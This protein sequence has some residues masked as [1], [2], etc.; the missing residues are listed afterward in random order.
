[1]Q[2]V[3]V[4]IFA[5]LGAALAFLS[6]MASAQT[7]PDTGRYAYH[8]GMWWDGGWWPIMMFG[9]LFMLLFLAVLI[10][11]VIFLVRRD[12][13]LGQ[14]AM[15][16]QS[17]PLDILKERFARGEIDKNEFEERRRVLGE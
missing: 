13:G 6:G 4:P 14:S 2:R 1:M 5:A 10:A 9:P 16:P 12:G 8:P 11:A 7:S 3:P 17:T 15:P